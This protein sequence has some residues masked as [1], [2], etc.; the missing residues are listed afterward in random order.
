M[1]ALAIVANV[2][3]QNEVYAL[4]K[5]CFLPHFLTV[6]RA[7]WKELQQGHED[8]QRLTVR[9]LNYKD[10]AESMKFAKL[11]KGWQGLSRAAG[12]RKKILT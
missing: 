8:P 5:R 9:V 11:H 12:A 6:D 10:L 7:F 2:G 4:R 3:L 1:D